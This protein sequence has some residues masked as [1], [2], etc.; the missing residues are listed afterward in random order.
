MMRGVPCYAGGLDETCPQ[1]DVVLGIAGGRGS[2]LPLLHIRRRPR[3]MMSRDGPVTQ[4]FVLPEACIP[5]AD[6]SAP[7]LNGQVN[8]LLANPERR[9]LI[10][11]RRCRQNID[12]VVM[13]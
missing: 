2:S 10:A 5:L 7:I 6:E 12:A 11:T 13:A 4:R 8:H 1:T 3:W 9:S